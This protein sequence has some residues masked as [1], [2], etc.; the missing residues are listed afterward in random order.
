MSRRTTAVCFLAMLV[1]ACSSPASHDGSGGTSG[2][3]GATS[4]GG[5]SS[6]GGSTSSGGSSGGTTGSGGATASGGTT[7]SGG[8]TASGGTTGSGGATAS[9]GTTGSG[10]KA[11]SSGS[12]GSVANG[13]S[14]G[15]TSTGRG[16]VT[17]GGGSMACPAL[18]TAPIAAGSIVQF[19]DNGAWCWY[20]DER[21]VVDTKANK[22]VVGS[23]AFGGSRNG[24]VE[25]VVYDMA[26]GMKKGP[27]V[28]GT[29]SV[30]DHSAAALVIRPDGKYVAMWA[31]HHVD[32]NSYYSIFDGSSWGASKK[33][34]WKTQGCTWDGDST[35][36]IT[37]SN[38]WI[39]RRR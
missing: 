23:V 13:G 6:T 20:Q 15:S 36:S 30:D 18:P 39:C 21:V 22:L 37:Y 26:T 11:G 3:G 1:A 4:T 9:G 24:A 35:H 7:G 14:A 31:G 16:G 17:G 28:L 2:S 8:A 34:D 10:G 25:A 12:G 5:S 29:L 38:L 32:C 19:N 33:F 27:S